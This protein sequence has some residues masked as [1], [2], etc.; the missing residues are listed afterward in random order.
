VTRRIAQIVLLAAAVSTAAVSVVAQTAQTAQ[1]PAPP[2][3]P[4]DWRGPLLASFDDVWQTVH[5]T[6]W[7]PT[8]N[9]VDWDGIRRQ[10]RPEVEHAASPQAARHVINSMLAQ[11][12][13][14]H[15]V[16]LS[17][18]LPDDVLP[19]E[20]SV[21][22]EFR[23]LDTSVVI[24]SLEPNS[25]AARAGVRPGDAIVEIDGHATASLIAAAVGA[26]A[27]AKV[28]DA[29]RRVYR[30][31]HG[32]AGSAATLA[33][34]A[35]DGTHRVLKVTRVI[36]SGIPLKMGNLP[37]MRVRVS[38]RDAATPARKHVGVIA[39]NL[40]MTPISVPVD[41]AIDRYRHAD[42]IV[43]D[44][45]GNPGGL[46]GMITGIAGHLLADPLPLATSHMRGATLQYVANPRL[47][48]SDGR[49]V[50]PFAGPVAILVDELTGST[51]ECF[52]AALQSLD[53]ARV[54]GRP[55]M[56]QALPAVT[57]QLADGDVFMYA[58]GDF[59]TST[60]KR[61]EGAGVTPDVVV[62]LS[63][64]SLAAGHDATLD[65]ALAWIDG[66]RR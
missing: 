46:A 17:T 65:A 16:V 22:V 41:E 59:V 30:V 62:P 20:A 31:L 32:D 27:R 66:A 9:G 57:K 58:L 60:G 23:I 14:S 8:F 47:A 52:A 3:S 25:T 53:R 38:S 33:L 35:A 39:F 61:I 21:P 37:M 51:S 55:T 6:F 4:F 36:E 48:T 1:V 56:G 34:R 49:R 18:A 63:V 28:F 13:A 24:T 42:G 64:A 2:V 12:K 7:D 19:G 43:I 29:W 45:R 40:W 54:F 5:D 11:L 44:L 10:L 26:D 15:F 50:E